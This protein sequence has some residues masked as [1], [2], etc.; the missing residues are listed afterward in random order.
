MDWYASAVVFTIA[1]CSTMPGRDD[2]AK[3][4]APLSSACTHASRSAVTI[5]LP[6]CIR[7]DVYDLVM[8]EVLVHLV[9][10]YQ[11]TGRL[12][13]CEACVS[14]KVFVKFKR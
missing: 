10:D 5:S 9:H 13:I 11:C 1:R 14:I 6:R 7:L 2:G 12:R 3:G 8:A 4:S